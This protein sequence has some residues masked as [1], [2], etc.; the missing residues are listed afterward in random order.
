MQLLA[1]KSSSPARSPSKE[2]GDES[3]ATGHSTSLMSDFSFKL[4]HDQSSPASSPEG[5][6]AAF[7]S[8]RASDTA[9]SEELIPEEELRRPSK[10]SRYALRH[11]TP[12]RPLLPLHLGRVEAGNGSQALSSPDLTSMGDVAHAAR[13]AFGQSTPYHADSSNAFRS[14]P[15]TFLLSRYCVRNLPRPLRIPY[16]DSKCSGADW[17]KVQWGDTH[18][19]LDL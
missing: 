16:K 3:F 13:L 2:G 19:F 18:H 17:G 8:K 15:A 6:P 14:S 11:V 12:H 1:L 5:E 7:T 4:T 9:A 10:R